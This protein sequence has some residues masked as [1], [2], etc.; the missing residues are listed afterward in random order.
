M[1]AKEFNNEILTNLKDKVDNIINN[2]LNK[3]SNGV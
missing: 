1:N 2:V 3:Y